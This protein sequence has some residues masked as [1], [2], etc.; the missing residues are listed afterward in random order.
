MFYRFLAILVL[1][2]QTTLLNGQELKVASIFSDGAVL[3]QN[4]KV[5]IWGSALPNSE[6]TVTPSWSA[7]LTVKAGESGEW[8]AE[9][10]TL[11]G[12]YTRHSVKISSSGKEIKLDDILFGEVWLISGQ[13]NMEMT[14]H[15]EKLNSMKIEGGKKVI[16]G[17]DDPYLREFKVAR[18]ERFYPQKEVIL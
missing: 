2:L 10:K 1:A 18:C 15:E 17:A 12:D 11:A 9:L 5:K 7:T 16:E 4:K 14:F 6:I 8:C 13:S 3:Q